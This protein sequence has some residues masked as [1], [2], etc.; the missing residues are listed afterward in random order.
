MVTKEHH[1]P[2]KQALLP[3]VA[4]VFIIM[5]GK[6]GLLNKW[7]L[8]NKVLVWFGLISYPMY[9]WHWPI[10]SMARIVRMEEP[11]I[12]FRIL[13]FP[14]CVAL[15]WLTTKLIENPLRFG[16]YGKIKT[17]VLFLIMVAV[18]FVGYRAFKT[19][20]FPKRF[21]SKIQALQKILI[22]NHFSNSGFWTKEEGWNPCKPHDKSFDLK[23]CHIKKPL[24]INKKTIAIWGDSHAT[25]LI[26]GLKKYFGEEFNIMDR[27]GT[28]CG[29]V[30]KNEKTIFEEN[31]RKMLSDILI[32]KPSKVILAAKWIDYRDSLNG[33]KDSINELRRSGIKDI[34]VL[35]PLPIWKNKLPKELI[36][37]WIIN[38]SY[39]NRLGKLDKKLYV[40]LDEELKKISKDIGVRYISL[41]KL[42]CNKDGC[43][44]MVNAKPE[45]VL[46]FD[47]AHLTEA[48]SL[49]LVERL[50][51]ELRLNLEK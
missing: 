36:R 51:N 13:A 43:E 15:A 32:H 23:E 42:L 19:K 29:P 39:V 11:T 35:G 26:P 16:G 45:N 17:I 12:W 21:P 25:H 30:L 38:D 31:K 50:K 18:G 49:Y 44:V 14:V 22:E 1:F 5:A 9:L 6:D 4:T 27:T 7:I 2:G 41:H 33:L 3:I 48:G 20:G 8:S 47:E 28:L 37:Y 34:V 10:L 24:N 40:G 46:A